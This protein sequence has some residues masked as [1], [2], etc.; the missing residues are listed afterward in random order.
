MSPTG[1]F[2][3]PALTHNRPP[4]RSTWA[5]S[6]EPVPGIVFTF[7]STGADATFN[8]CGV[9][10][11]IIADIVTGSGPQ[12]FYFADSG[13]VTLTSTSPPVG[14]MQDLHLVEVNIASGAPVP[15]GCDATIAAMSFGT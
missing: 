12:K 8:D 7:P 15:G 13:S 2:F 5:S 11:N 9:C 4:P 10:T 1:W 3:V 14:T 6:F